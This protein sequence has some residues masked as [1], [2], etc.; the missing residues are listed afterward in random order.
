MDGWCVQ[1]RAPGEREQALRR[2]VD[3][4]ASLKLT[5]EEKDYI[6]ITCPYLDPVYLNFLQ[7]YCYD[8]AAA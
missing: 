1:G 8:P 7:G 5:K 4:M 3:A 2:S 6:G